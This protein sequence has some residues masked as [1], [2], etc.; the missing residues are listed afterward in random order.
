MKKM[1]KQR[2]IQTSRGVF[3]YHVL[4]ENG[5][6]IYFCHGNSLSAGTYLPF[7][8]LL[9]GHGFKV[10]A[11]DLRGHGFSTKE[12]TG[13]PVSWDM[14][15]RDIHGLV[16]EIADPPV[17]GIGHSIGGYFLYAAAA[18]FPGLFSKLV[19]IDP[20]IFPAGILW[21]AA[22]MRK[23]GLAGMMKLP[24]MTRKKKHE[25]R[26]REHAFSHYSGKGM[27]R[28]WKSEFVKAYVD[29]AIEQDTTDTWEL[30]CSPE[31]EAG[32]YEAVPLD[33][34]RHAG[35]I[36]IPV[37]VARGEKSDLFYRSA[38]EKLADRLAD[39]TFTELEGLGHFMIME[40][41][42]KIISI[43]LDFL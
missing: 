7:L 19:L 5:P 2:F 9:A 41:P 32:I 11:G 24:K 13:L 35:K 36:K 37:M 27:F 17:T 43:I 28:S 8:R 33:T 10:L 31:F 38:A 26:S 3:H 14:F 1:E 42:E 40:D 22:F 6:Q 25:F 30:C 16:R 4:G 39:C 23:T 34:W 29:T 18:M 20:I 15:V 12:R 21:A